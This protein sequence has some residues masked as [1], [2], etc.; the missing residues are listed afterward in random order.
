MGKG[1]GGIFRVIEPIAVVQI[2]PPVLFEPKI[3]VMWRL[4]W[5]P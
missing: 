4:P 1:A 2:R 5:R 3:P